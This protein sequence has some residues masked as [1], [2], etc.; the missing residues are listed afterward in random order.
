MHLCRRHIS[1][2][3]WLVLL[4]KVASPQFCPFKSLR[5]RM[6]LIHCALCVNIRAIGPLN[7][8]QQVH[9]SI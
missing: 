4:T 9:K 2:A 3:C 7:S 1:P 6:A 8:R 5:C